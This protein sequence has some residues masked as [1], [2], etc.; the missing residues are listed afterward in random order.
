MVIRA[1]G[2]LSEVPFQEAYGAGLYLPEPGFPNMK[3][4]RVLGGPVSAMTIVD[5]WL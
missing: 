5:L 2:E 4:R 1:F 3:S